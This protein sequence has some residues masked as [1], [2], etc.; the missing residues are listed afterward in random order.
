MTKI[1][2]TMEE[3]VNVMYQKIEEKYGPHRIRRMCKE[4]MD[5][6]SLLFGVERKERHEFNKLMAEEIIKRYK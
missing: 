5:K 3:R 6:M 2:P 4:E 1:E